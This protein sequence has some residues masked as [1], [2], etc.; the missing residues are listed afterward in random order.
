ML[1]KLTDDIDTISCS[2]KRKGVYFLDLVLYEATKNI[3][4]QPLSLSLLIPIY[5]WEEGL[6][7][8]Q[9]SRWS[10]IRVSA[11]VDVLLSSQFP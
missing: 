2:E 11:C 4:G 6:N 5:I 9:K 3:H 1:L 7:C 8:L 10:G